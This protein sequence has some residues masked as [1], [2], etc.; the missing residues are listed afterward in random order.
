MAFSTEQIEAVKKWANKMR[1][2]CPICK[3]RAPKFFRDFFQL[4]QLSSREQAEGGVEKC[5]FLGL[6]CSYC[7]MLFLVDP[8]VS[9]VPL[10][11]AK[12]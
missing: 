12:S 6:A 4:N 9:G 1:L 5:L 2:T 7:G 10:H 3:A 8:Q 11:E